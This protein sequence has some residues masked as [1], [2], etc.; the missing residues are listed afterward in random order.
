MIPAISQASTSAS[1]R[2]RCSSAPPRDSSNFVWDQSR[3]PGLGRP[4]R[5]GSGPSGGFLAEN[6]LDLDVEGHLVAEN[7]RIVGAGYR[8]VVADPEI[9]AVDLGSCAEAGPG[10]TKGIG[11][12][13]VGLHRQG[14]RL[15]DASDGQVAV[16]Q[17]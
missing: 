9:L 12:E 8:P 13:T 17:I 4:A 10:P 1:M 7:H 11:G 5:L 2:E 3:G 14:H 6:R 15:G 16:D